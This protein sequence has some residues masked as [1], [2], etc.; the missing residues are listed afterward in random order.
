TVNPNPTADAGD[1]ESICAGASADLSASAS[2]GT[3]PYTYSWNNGLGDGATHT[4]TP[5]QTTTYTV[6]VTDA[7]GCEDTDEVIITVNPNPTADAGEDESICAGTSADL[8]ASASGGTSPYTYSWDN[9]LGDGATH[10]VTPTQTTTYTVTVTDANGCKV[11]DEVAIIILPKPTVDAGPDV[12]ICQLD[13]VLLTATATGGSPGYTYVWSDGSVSE[14]DTI[15]PLGRFADAYFTMVVY[16]Q[17]LTQFA[18]SVVRSALSLGMY[19]YLNDYVFG[20]FDVEVNYNDQVA[21]ASVVT[22]R[23][24]KGGL[25][26]WTT[27]EISLLQNIDVGYGFYRTFVERLDI[28]WQIDNNFCIY[29]VLCDYWD[30]AQLLFSGDAESIQFV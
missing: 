18:N 30:V 15:T 4:V 19:E 27:E 28:E 26:A 9:G 8:S 20:V 14:I 16:D 29:P 13:S 17:D 6:T 11:E 2:G 21:G 25:F 3:S 10:T 12:E 1:D 22:F 23:L 24:R 7:N 5:S